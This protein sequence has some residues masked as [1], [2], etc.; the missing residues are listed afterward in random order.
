MGDEHGTVE[1]F[2]EVAG[3]LTELGG[4][5]HI[6]GGDAVDVGRADIAAGVHEGRP[7]VEDGPVAAHAYRSHLEDPVAKTR[8]EP[9][10]LNID[11]AELA[12]H[13]VP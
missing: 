12:I 8:A 10:R 2:E 4:V 5:E 1:S 11:D 9:G 13:R 3:H 6:T 7:L